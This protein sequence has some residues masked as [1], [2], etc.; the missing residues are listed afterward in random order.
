MFRA[1][2]QVDPHGETSGKDERAL[3]RNFLPGAAVW[4]RFLFLHLTADDRSDGVRC[5]LLHLRCGSVKPAEWYPRVP[6]RVFTSTPFFRDSVAKRCRISWNRTCSAPIA[7]RILLCVRRKASGSYI[8]PVFAMGTCM[9][10]LGAFCVPQSEAPP[11]VEELPASV[12]S[13]A[14]SVD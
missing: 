2:P 11:P 1:A 4:G 14:S 7:F 3:G 12:R 13:S 6:E 8:V 10:Y 5:I 9:N